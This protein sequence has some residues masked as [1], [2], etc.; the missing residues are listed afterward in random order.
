M[1]LNL[2]FTAVEMGLHSFLQYVC[3]VL[4]FFIFIYT[5]IFGAYLYQYLGVYYPVIYL[6][7]EIYVQM[8]AVK[9]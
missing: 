9:Q 3:N 4:I 1:N 8:N 5:R 2:P 7:S 6:C